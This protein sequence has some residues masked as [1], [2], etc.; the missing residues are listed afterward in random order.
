ML[1]HV[2]EVAGTTEYSF[3]VPYLHLFPWRPVRKASLSE[4]AIGETRIK[5]FWLTASSGPAVTPITL[6]IQ[7]YIKAGKGYQLAVPTT[8]I[9]STFY[10]DESAAALSLSEGVT[11]EGRSVETFGEIIED[12]KVLMKR[13]CLNGKVSI[14]SVNGHSGQFVYPC[15][16]LPKG[17][18][19]LVLG[20]SPNVISIYSTRL[21]YFQYFRL[22]YFGYSGGSCL[23]V[24]P[25]ELTPS[26]EAARSFT[27]G[28]VEDVAM[29][30]SFPTE[31]LGGSGAELFQFPEQVV[32]EVSNPDRCFFHWKVPV[33][34]SVTTATANQEGV[35]YAI[36]ENRST[37][38]GSDAIA[39][40]N[41]YL[42]AR[43]DVAMGGWLSTPVLY[44]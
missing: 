41:M 11:L 7:V 43:D 40:Y 12:V 15:D 9:I 44:T 14:L 35:S 37:T 39:D 23:K 34:K 28:W 21:T 5:F 36:T 22:P 8:S 4:V 13:P 10:T 16:G 27:I 20:V 32:F 3:E 31:N 24:T 42:S 19:P 30:E 25:T 18:D 26:S 1:A 33:Y 38:F 17:P 2:I 29:G 6:D